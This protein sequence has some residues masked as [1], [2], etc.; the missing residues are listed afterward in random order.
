M[1]TLYNKVACIK[2]GLVESMR[3]KVQD[4]SGMFIPSCITPFKN[5]FFAVD[6]T[7]LEIDTPDD[8]GQ[9]HGTAMTM[10]QEGEGEVQQ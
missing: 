7:D 5:V 4:N 2:Q 3:K 8:Q 1:S 6:N 10:F 9:L